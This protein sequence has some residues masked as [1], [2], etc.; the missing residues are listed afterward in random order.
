MHRSIR[1]HPCPQLPAVHGE[2]RR[3]TNK[4]ANWVTCNNSAMAAEKRKG[5][6]LLRE[7]LVSFLN[8]EVSEQGLKDGESSI[9]EVGGEEEKGGG[10]NQE[11]KL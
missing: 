2:D 4:Q 11:H 9:D 1:H 5:W 8:E 7:V 6:I 10:S 3:R